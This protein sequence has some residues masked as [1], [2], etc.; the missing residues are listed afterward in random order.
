VAAPR[1]SIFRN[2]HFTDLFYPKIFSA[3]NGQIFMENFMKK[4]WEITSIF[5]SKI[6]R[7]FPWKMDFPWKK[8]YEKSTPGV[9]LLYF[10]F[11]GRSVAVR[12]RVRQDGVVR[13]DARSPRNRHF[14]SRATLFLCHFISRATLFC[15]FISRETLYCHPSNFY[16][17]IHT[18][19]FSRHFSMTTLDPILRLRFTTPEGSFLNEFL[20]L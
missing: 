14:I 2:S 13:K 9:R 12:L 19:I 16:S 8:M 6:P 20:R 3:E 17:Y 5:P 18:Y 15:R 11:S 10:L 1:M 4:F 7:N